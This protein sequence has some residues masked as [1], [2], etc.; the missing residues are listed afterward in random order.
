MVL[1]D[2]F[3]SIRV[4][5]AAAFAL[6]DVITR[7]LVYSFYHNNSIISIHLRSKEIYGIWYDT[8]RN[9]FHTASLQLSQ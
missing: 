7:Y 3:Y 6:H 9:D 2:I 1:Y 4:P 5:P 8:T